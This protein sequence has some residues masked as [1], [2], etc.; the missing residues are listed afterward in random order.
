MFCKPFQRCKG[1]NRDYCS[2]F[3]AIF[4][5]TSKVVIV[6]VRLT[7]GKVEF[8]WFTRPKQKTDV[9]YEFGSNVLLNCLG[10]KYRV[11]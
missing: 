2:Q 8:D 11:L 3:S 6:F 7:L 9:K 5:T 10:C 4:E 1:K